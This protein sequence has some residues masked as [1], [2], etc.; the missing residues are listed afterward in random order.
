MVVF[1]GMANDVLVDLLVLPVSA[2]E[3]NEAAQRKG[4]AVIVLHGA[5]RSIVGQDH[6]VQNW[7]EITFIR[8]RLAD[9]KKFSSSMLKTNTACTVKLK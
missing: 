6:G 3:A 9:M 4:W 5:R 1:S 7:K 8:R 2:N